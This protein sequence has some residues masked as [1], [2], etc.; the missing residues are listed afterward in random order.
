MNKLQDKDPAM[1]HMLEELPFV[2]MPS[3]FAL[4]YIANEPLTSKSIEFYKDGNCQS[5]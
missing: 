2:N 1:I 3:G 4:K 5:A